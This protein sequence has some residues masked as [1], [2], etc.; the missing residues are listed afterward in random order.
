M[1][2]GHMLQSLYPENTMHVK[3]ITYYNRNAAALKTLIHIHFHSI[4]GC[5]IM[6]KKSD[7]KLKLKLLRLKLNISTRLC[8]HWHNHAFPMKLKALC[9]CRQCPLHLLQFYSTIES[10]DSLFDLYFLLPR[11]RKMLLT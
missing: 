6:E 2:H 7:K 3:A 11:R 10:C 8:A 1:S 9:Q 4:C 5:I